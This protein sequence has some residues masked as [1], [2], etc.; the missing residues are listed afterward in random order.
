[1]I[2]AHK[3]IDNAW[4]EFERY[5]T[6][7]YIRQLLDNRAAAL[8][9]GITTDMTLVLQILFSILCDLIYRSESSTANSDELKRIKSLITDL[10]MNLEE[11][12]NGEKSRLVSMESAIREV[13]KRLDTMETRSNQ[14]LKNTERVSFFN[15]I[16]LSNI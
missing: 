1:M 7:S 16:I 10:Q 5:S 4:S 12:Y 15:K 14:S 2:P 13:Q 8:G 9:R 3:H 6:N 11:S